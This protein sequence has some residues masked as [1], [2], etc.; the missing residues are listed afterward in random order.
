MTRTQAISVA[1]VSKN[2]SSFTAVRDVNLDVPSGQI[3]ALLGM[4][5]AGKTTLI[6]MIIGFQKPTTG[7]TQIFGMAPRD[8]IRRGLVGVVHQTGALLPE[9]TVTQTLKLFAATHDQPLPL[10]DILERTD[11]TALAKRRVGKLSGGEQQR[12]RLALALLPDP[13]LLILDEPTAGMD[14]VA[15]RRF[16]EL[17]RHQA[18]AGCT[19]VFATH[20]LAEAQDFAERTIIMRGGRIIRDGATEDIRRDATQSQLTISVPVSS[21]NEAE[22]ALANLPQS[23]RWQV[24]W[25]DEVGAASSADTAS[26]DSPAAKRN[27]APAPTER[28]L[29]VSGHDLDDAARALLNIAGTHSLELTSATLEDAFASLVDS[30]DC[31]D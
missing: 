10:D 15:R 18:D 27:R 12:V 22:A 17:M 4:N 25:A 8:A 31:Q 13:Q 14:A 29:T 21:V 5:G 28:T 26:A 3:M 2:F 11:L 9:Y 16:W 1:E 7:S 20:Y 30:D 6:D 23:D 19:I 24:S